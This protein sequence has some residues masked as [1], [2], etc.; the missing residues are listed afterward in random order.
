MSIFNSVPITKRRDSKSKI[1]YRVFRPNRI[2]L[3]REDRSY[4]DSTY[5]VNNMRKWMNKVL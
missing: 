2:T 5:E 4:E 1:G 3:F